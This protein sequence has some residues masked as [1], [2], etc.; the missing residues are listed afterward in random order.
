MLATKPSRAVHP[1]PHSLA[2][3][4]AEAG[5]AQEDVLVATDTDL[6]LDGAYLEGWVI[7]TRDGL[8]FFSRAP[9][10]GHYDLL[11]K[12]ALEEVES[13]RTDARV[14][15]GFL[16]VKKEGLY[17]EV[18]RFSNRYTD[19]FVRLAG[20]INGLAQ[21]RQIDGGIAEEESEGRCRKCGMR[22]PERRMT[23]CP[24][25]IKRG[26]VFM[27]FLGRTRNYLPHTVAACALVVLTILIQLIPAQFQRVLIDNVFLN[28]PL[29]AWFA[30]VTELFNFHEPMEWLYLLVMALAV[31]TAAGSMVAWARER[32]SVWINNR[33]GYDLRKEVFERLQELAVRYH[34]THPVGQLMTRCSQDVEA[35]QGFINQLTSGFGYQIILVVSVAIVMLMTSWQL[36]LWAVLPAPLVMVCTVWFYRRIVPDWQKYWTSRSNLSNAL[37]GSLNGVRVVKAFA[38]EARESSRFDRYSVRF[39]DAG[40]NV[41]YANAWFYPA[42]GWLFQF[43]SYAVWLTGG[44]ALLHATSLGGDQELTVGTLVLFLSYLAMFY[45]PLNSLTQMSTWFTSFTTQA[46]RVFEVLDEDPEVAESDDAVD[47]EIAGAIAFRNV[48]FGYDPHI[49]VIHDVS[50]AIQ[51]GEMVGIVGHSGSGKSTTANLIMRFYDA[52]GGVIT[53]DGTDIKQIH[54][55]SLRRQVGLVAQDPFLFRGSIADN[56]AYGNPDVAPERVLNAA[57]AANAH[58][59]ITRIH[60]GYDAR[61]GEHGSGLSGGERQRV[62]IAR[63]LL[64]DPRILILDEA[65]SS[66]DAI[67]EREIQR[68]LEAL[69]AGRTTIA[70]AHRLSTL[71]NCHR[72][73]VFEEGVIRE[74]GSHDHLMAVGGIYKRLVDI[75]TQLNANGTSAQELAAMR[76]NVGQNGL[77]DAN[78]HAN[79]HGAVSTDE[80]ENNHGERSRPPEISYLDPAKLCITTSRT[81][82]M[83]VE[84]ASE[85][86]PHVRAYRCFPTSRPSEFIALWTGSSALEHQEIGI[87]RR[88][89][90][91]A[92]DSRRAVELELAKR[93]FIHYIKRIYCITEDIGFLTWEVDTDKGRMEFLMKR[94]ERS[95]VVETPNNGCIILDLDMNRYEIEDLDRLDV[96]S[97]GKFLDYI[98]W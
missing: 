20:R 75:Q 2:T 25:C 81:G 28:E 93:Y 37:H 66:V 87:I 47:V 63:A 68:A 58:M 56:I 35:L 64:H 8:L 39:R 5:I 17:E 29:P 78:G 90:E 54:K 50:F 95:A 6:Q 11:K 40:Y 61:L 48:T 14:G 41:G 13:A 62:A 89:H 52:T 38:Q 69:S 85:A 43:G 91:L 80:R 82:G 53:V 79:G 12:I 57:L 49:P 72:I 88:L 55:H 67:A 4:L 21:G 24:K 97:R 59:F 19:K 51:P 15:S 31:T 7:V 23:I 92:A 36:T 84:Y 16:E 3:S 46:H 27:R 76:D 9:Q 96:D 65:T 74:Q 94:W 18:A 42:M 77:A 70:I 98:Y 32:L 10:N 33:M 22:V 30:A 60:D 1:L 44:Y 34:D 83:R 26:Q 86:Y 73:L 45:A 71:R